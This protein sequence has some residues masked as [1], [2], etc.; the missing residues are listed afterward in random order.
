MQSHPAATVPPAPMPSDAH[1]SPAAIAAVHS[2]ASNTRDT[3]SPAAAR[4][5][6]PPSSGLSGG[7]GISGS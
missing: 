2:S 1:Q 3:P 4:R 7:R 6:L 5:A